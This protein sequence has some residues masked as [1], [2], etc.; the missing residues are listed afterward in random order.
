[1]KLGTG[2]FFAFHFRALHPEAYD[3]TDEEIAWKS[4]TH[5]R[6]EDSTRKKS[7]THWRLSMPITFIFS[8]AA[9]TKKLQ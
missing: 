7:M 8:W 9:L 3:R 4:G 2:F 6:Y 5:V 1:M